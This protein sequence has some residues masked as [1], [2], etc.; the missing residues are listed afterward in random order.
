MKHRARSASA[1]FALLSMGASQGLAQTTDF[2]V[3]LSEGNA[4]GQVLQLDS[5]GNIVGPFATGLDSPRGTAIAPNGDF[6]VSVQGFGSV[7]RFTPAGLQSTLL[8]A[9][10]LNSAGIGGPLAPFDLEVNAE[11]DLF[12][13]NNATDQILRVDGVTGEVSVFAEVQ[14]TRG[15]GFAPDGTL[16]VSQAAG[17][18]SQVDTDGN[19]SLFAAGSSGIIEPFDVQVDSQ[20]NVFAVN[21]LDP[22]GFTDGQILRFTPEG[23]VSIFS[24]ADVRGLAIGPDDSVFGSTAAGTIVQI[25][26]GGIESVFAS[27]LGN[28]FAFDLVFVPTPG[29]VAVL[30]AGGLVATRR[31]R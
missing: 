20:G 22:I 14:G 19:V 25:T 28:P 9:D 6:F 21:Q 3:L 7:E 27:G 10:T 2:F 4:G 8:N 29:S 12:V 17:A 24:D 13:S 15:L 5:S 26:P 31:R 11:G 16:F 1:V 18:I 30:A 23:D